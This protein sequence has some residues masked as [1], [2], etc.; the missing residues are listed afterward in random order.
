M[1]DT[2]DLCAEVLAS[3]QPPTIWCGISS[4]KHYSKKKRFRRFER[5]TATANRKENYAK[6]K[7]NLYTSWFEMLLEMLPSKKVKLSLCLTN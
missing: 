2:L 3:E 4:W 7:T 5:G 6:R 1:K